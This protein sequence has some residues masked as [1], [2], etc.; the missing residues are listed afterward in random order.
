MLS[1]KDEVNVMMK[2][3]ADVAMGG[4]SYWMFGYGFSYGQPSN[5]FIG[6]GTFFVGTTDEN[7]LSTGHE[8]A[9]YLFQFSF[10]ATATTIVSG[11]IAGRTRF[12]AYLVFSFVNT[13]VY[14]V[15]AHWVWSW[16]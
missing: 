13:I 2:N 16:V 11:C 7:A 3:I 6:M 4:L 14:A 15:P 1:K 9:R 10:A 8:F 12:G 5:S